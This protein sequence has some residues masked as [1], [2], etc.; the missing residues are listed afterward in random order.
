MIFILLIGKDL[1]SYSDTDTHDTF[2]WYHYPHCFE[3]YLLLPSLL[4][5][6][7]CHRLYPQ[8][9]ACHPG[10]ARRYAPLAGLQGPE[11]GHSDLLVLAGLGEEEEWTS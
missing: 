7:A 11:A 9:V 3:H 5:L 2:Y 4:Y 6:D 8:E 1:G 10:E